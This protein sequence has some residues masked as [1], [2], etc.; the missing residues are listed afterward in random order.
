MAEFAG[1]ALAT[2]LVLGVGAGWAFALDAATFLVSAAFLIRLRPRP[3]GEAVRHDGAPELREG[4]REVRPRTWVW[5]IVAVFS[6]GCS[7]CFGP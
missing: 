7:S 6:F 4:W 1:P 3:R 2:A 5:A